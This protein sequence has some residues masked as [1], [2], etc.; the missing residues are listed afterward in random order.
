MVFEYLDMDLKKLLE[1]GKDCFTPALVKVYKSRTGIHIVGTVCV[2]LRHNFFFIVVVAELHVSTVGRNCF[3]SHSSHT[4]QR[5]KTTKSVRLLYIS[6][7][8]GWSFCLIEINWNCANMQAGW[9]GGPYKIGRFWIGS[10][11]QHA[12]ECIDPRSSDIMVSG[13]RSAIRHQILCN[14]RWHLESRMHFRG[15]GMNAFCVAVVTVPDC[16]IPILCSSN[17]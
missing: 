9:L 10:G 15:N 11:F 5:L 1:K 7:P 12:S 2:S 3:L 16:P 4:A 6:Q 17:S 14:W 8:N 13:T